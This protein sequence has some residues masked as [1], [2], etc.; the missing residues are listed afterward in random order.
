MLA[1]DEEKLPPPTP[2]VAAH[3][4]STQNC[5][6]WPACASQPLGTTTASSSDGISSSAALIVVHRRPPKRGTANVYGIR[7]TEP[8]RFGTAVSQNCSGSDSVMPTL[9]RLMHD[10]RPQH[11]DAEAEMLG[12]DR[13]DQVPAR[14]PRARVRPRTASSSGSQRSIQRPRRS[15]QV[16]NRRRC[17][18]RR[19]GGPA[20]WVLYRPAVGA[21]RRTL[22][23]HVETEPAASVR[24]GAWP[25]REPEIDAAA[26]ADAFAAD[27]LHGTSSA[28]LAAAAG[29]A[30][31]TLGRRMQGHAAPRAV[32]SEV[33]RVL[34]HLHAADVQSAGRSA[35]NR[36]TAAALAL[37]EH[38]ADRPAA[39]APA[40]AAPRTTATLR[41]PRRWPRLRA[42]IPRPDR[43]RAA[44][45]Y[46]PQ[47]D[48]MPR[49]HRPSPAPFTARPSPSPRAAPGERR[50]WRATLAALAA[51]VVPLAPSRHADQWPAA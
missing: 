7:S 31:P 50:P 26:L 3:A 39:R 33:E 35:H 19:H 13:E 32:E 10:D 44:P 15:A 42:H 18:C 41:W 11:P 2:A 49:S 9:P 30:K 23:P 24:S 20:R 22:L 29:V 47:T 43:G 45:R 4:S 28:T 46:S 14:D 40:R 51:S 12:E 8:I 21:S 6:S 34:D 5:V 48:S 17:S 37:L 38:A 1:I 36:T 25:D 16:M 27:G